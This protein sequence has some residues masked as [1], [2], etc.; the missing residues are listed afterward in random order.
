MHGDVLELTQ[1][2]N[3]LLR[4]VALGVLVHVLNGW[5]PLVAQDTLATLTVARTTASRLFE[6]VS[7]QMAADMGTVVSDLREALV[8]QSALVSIMA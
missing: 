6:T 3:I 2:R 5:K 4:G 7:N 1:S 8:A